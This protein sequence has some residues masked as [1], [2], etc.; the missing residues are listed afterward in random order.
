MDRY[1]ARGLKDAYLLDELVTNEDKKSIGGITFQRFIDNSQDHDNSYIIASPLHTR[2]SMYDFTNADMDKLY[3]F[4]G[5]KTRGTFTEAG[6]TI[7]GNAN[8]LIEGAK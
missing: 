4:K 5:A 2:S 1:V 3:L 8:I 6:T 7:T